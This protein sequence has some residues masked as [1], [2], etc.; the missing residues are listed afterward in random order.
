MERF[1][2][3]QLA[4][5]P[6]SHVQPQPFKDIIGAAIA[7]DVFLDKSP[8]HVGYPTPSEIHKPDQEYMNQDLVN[9]CCLFDR[10]REFNMDTQNAT[11]LRLSVRVDSYLIKPDTSLKSS[12]KSKKK[13]P[14]STLL[15]MDVYPSWLKDY[16]DWFDPSIYDYIQASVDGMKVARLVN[17]LAANEEVNYQLQGKVDTDGLMVPIPKMHKPVTTSDESTFSQLDLPAYDSKL[18]AD[19]NPSGLE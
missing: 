7:L 17:R 12:F 18:T 13:A 14:P 15:S 1:C 10:K 8:E 3:S 2:A 16:L 4:N 19:C 11:K 9:I 5:A 6:A